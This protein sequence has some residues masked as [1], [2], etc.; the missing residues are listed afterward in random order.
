MTDIEDPEPSDLDFVS[1]DEEATEEDNAPPMSSKAASMLTMPVGRL[2][3]L[4]SVQP[5]SNTIP[6]IY[7]D[8]KGPFK[9]PDLQGEVY[10]QSFI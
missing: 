4:A 9:V 10:A 3:N 6:I 1:D 2:R 7:T 8:I 5:L